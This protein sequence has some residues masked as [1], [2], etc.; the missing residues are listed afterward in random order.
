MSDNEYGDVPKKADGSDRTLLGT[1][2][3]EKTNSIGFDSSTLS[4]EREVALKYYKGDMSDVPA[5]EGRSKAVA[6]TVSDAIE[7]LL[8]DLVE[9]FTGEDVAA[10]VPRG[11]E[12]EEA[13]E[14]ETD[15]INHV[16]FNEN[17]G[18]SILSA[19]FKDA[20]QVKTGIFK[21][22]S[23]EY[24]DVETFVGKDEAE[25]AVA[26]QNNPD[27]VEEPTRNEDGTYDFKI[28]TKG[29]KVC[30]EAVAPED[31]TVSADTVSLRDTPYC[32]HR[33]RKRYYELIEAGL[34]K[35]KVDMCSTYG[36]EGEQIERARDTAGE[37]DRPAS[38]GSGDRRLIE[39][40]EHY[41]RK[42][43]KYTRVLTD[44]S[45]SVILEGP[46]TVS[47]IRFSAITPYPVPHRFYGESVADR[48]IE[49]QR[50][51]TA[52]TRMSLDN[53]YFALNGRSEI[54]MSKINEWTIPDLLNNAPNMPVRVARQ[55]AITPLVS[56]GLRFDPFSA[57]EYFATRTEQRTGIVRNAQG[58]NPDTLHDTASGAMA[59]MTA[60]QKR[61]RLMARY[62]AVGVKEMFLGVHELIR[63]TA[64]GPMK[65]R[66]R[67][68]WV[69]IDPTKW[70][71][72]S[73]M[74]IEIGVGASGKEAQMLML[75]QGLQTMQE[76]VV[77]QGGAQG[78]LVTETNVYNLTKKFFE[79]GLGFKNAEL[80]LTDPKA[81]PKEGE[82]PPEPQ[83]DPAVLEAQA[84]MQMAQM[85]LE[86]KQQ[87]AQMDL[88]GRQQLMAAEFQAKQ[89]EAA[90]RLE[91]DRENNAAKQAAAR[92]DAML[93]AQLK[94]DEAAAN[95]AA[96]ERQV[97]A[98]IALRERQIAAELDLEER[99]FA[100]K[101]QLEAEGMA[102][103]A[104]IAV[105]SSDVQTGGT[106][107]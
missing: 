50:I 10:F 69:D 91:M 22:R 6:T 82:E 62:F 85:E 25:A 2:Q 87:L 78:P 34:P 31:F 98:E 55:G 4:K 7:T 5:L 14:Q 44:A 24:E 73:D 12:D 30:V 15:Y 29:K 74:T 54:D 32:A 90:A 65:A 105:N 70:G 61:V 93:T 99:Q 48:L 52:L 94:R 23:E 27:G 81:P 80:Y 89:M 79:K 75:Q 83:P 1:L 41:L 53:G 59:L 16:F 33:A 46:E 64:T 72:R 17:D 71:S 56:S 106:G 60:S 88:E 92:E 38:G 11:E 35:A 39:V 84:K 40:V 37:G 36:R 63:E 96:R 95:I 58:L 67:N 100:A 101:L 3:Y 77:Q 43:G 20:L 76:I 49:N 86:G 102:V 103:D 66:L 57:L 9:I 28:R 51:D 21:W 19:A 13:A 18:F 42:D 68:K 104:S 26:I 47:S 8:P 107:G 97:S 45:T